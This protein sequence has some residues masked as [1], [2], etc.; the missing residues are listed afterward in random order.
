MEKKKFK[1]TKLGA[2]LLQRIPKAA[3]I[4][5][6]LLP[7][8]GVLG[9]VKNIIQGSPDLSAEERS[10]LL[11]LHNDFEIE[12]YQLE[13]R[14][15][16][17]ARTREVE[18]AKTGKTD[19]LMYVAGYTA[20]LTFLLMVVSVIFFGDLVSDNPLFHQLMGII[21]GVALTVFGYYF[22]TSK[23]SSDKNKLLK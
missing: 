3:G 4:V 15:R 6:D 16:E 5:G 1:E 14:D 23:S 22:G 19:H 10:E 7:D 12:M 18:M 21:E 8:K 11:K 2:L 13:V 17:S 9:I 20:L